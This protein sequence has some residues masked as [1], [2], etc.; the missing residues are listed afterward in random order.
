MKTSR[1]V[2]KNKYGFVLKTGR[3]K[4]GRVTV[5]GIQ[6]QCVRIAQ[7]C[8]IKYDGAMYYAHPSVVHV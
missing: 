7:L 1:S 5:A 4:V 3:P 6:M 8:L 2:I